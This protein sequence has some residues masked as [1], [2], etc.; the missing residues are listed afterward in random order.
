MQSQGS[1]CGIYGEHIGTGTFSLII[2]VLNIDCYSVRPYTPVIHHLR[3][4]KMAL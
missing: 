2:F 4:G 1:S 3:T